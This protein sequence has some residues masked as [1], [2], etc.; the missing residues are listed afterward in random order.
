VGNPGQLQSLYQWL[1]VTPDFVPAD[2]M[3][4]RNA[5]EEAYSIPD[6]VSEALSDYYKS[7]NQALADF[8]KTDLSCWEQR[9]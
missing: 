6:S 7:H 8:L 9:G 3:E 5:A 2:I 4:K 1:G